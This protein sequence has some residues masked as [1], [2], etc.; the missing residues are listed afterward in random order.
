[1]RSQ[2]RFECGDAFHDFVLEDDAANDDGDG[3]CEVAHEAKGCCGGCNVSGVDLGLEGYQ[4]RLEVRPDAN[5]CY[6]LVD[7][8]SSPGGLGREVNEETESQGHEKHAEPNRRQISACLLDENPSSGGHERE[9]E[10]EW[11]EIDS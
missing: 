7:D 4:G 9:G 2:G 10:N 5:T 11:E 8:D 1:M 6:D 3:C